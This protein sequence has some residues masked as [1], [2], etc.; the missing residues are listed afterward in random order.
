MLS[1]LKGETVTLQ[2]VTEVTMNNLG[3]YT[4]DGCWDLLHSHFCCG[5]STIRYCVLCLNGCS[6]TSKERSVSLLLLILPVQ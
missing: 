5:C 2:N 4:K 3:C 6:P 1:Y